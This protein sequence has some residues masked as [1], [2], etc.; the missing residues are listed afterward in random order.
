MDPDEYTGGS[1]V[2]H[3][4]AGATAG[5][6]EHCGM[7]P[8]D[9]VK[10]HI[11]AIR[12]GSI[13]LSPFAAGKEIYSRSGARGF[14][15]G[16]SAVASGAAPAHAF[17][18]VTYEAAKDMLVG[19][20]EGHH[21]FRIGI[22]GAMATMVSDGIMAPMDA[23]KQRMQ[24]HATP[25]RGLVD[26]VQTVYKKGGL[27][28]FYA[29][30]TTT[31]VLNG[32][33]HSFYFAGYESLLKLMGHDRSEYNPIVHCVSGGG[34]GMIAAGLTNPLDLVR[35]RLQT[36]GEVKAGPKYSGMLNTIATIWKEEG[37]I[38]FSR[39]VGPRMLFHSMSAAI[40]WSVYEYMKVMLD[41]Y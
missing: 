37:V 31:L 36:Q 24:L 25:Y 41:K 7:F 33:Y 32:P 17:Q 40:C 27:R 34:A 4:I 38:G 19:N 30:Y 35:T 2:V 18:F 13:V 3:L 12:P 9:T 11:Q 22:A 6:A 23:V 28:T 15:R 20:M 16:I 26:C 1:F 39:G 10:T 8:I 14:F 5:T 21:P 29:G